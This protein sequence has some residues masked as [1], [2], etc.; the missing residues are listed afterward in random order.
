MH[1]AHTIFFGVAIT[2]LYRNWPVGFLSWT[3]NTI[4]NDITVIFVKVC[5]VKSARRNLDHSDAVGSLC[6]TH[7]ICAYY[8]HVYFVILE[9]VSEIG[10]NWFL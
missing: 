3:H 2:S 5:Y 1:F 4:G 6:R 7:S 8:S 10:K 9:M